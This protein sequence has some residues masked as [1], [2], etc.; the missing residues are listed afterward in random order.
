M[1]ESK[2]KPFVRLD[3]TSLTIPD[4]E[5][6]VRERYHVDMS[7]G[8]W[9]RIAEARA[10]VYE[11]IERGVTL[12]GVTTGVGSQKDYSFDDESVQEFNERLIRAHAP[13]IPGYNISPAEVRA[14]LLIL[15]NGY[16]EG[17]S[18]IRAETVQK[19]L[20]GLNGDFIPEVRDNCSVGAGDL[21]P[22][23][24][25]AAA[26][27][28]DSDIEFKFAAKEAL[29]L[30]CSNAISLAKAALAVIECHR[31]MTAIDLVGAVALEGFRGNPQALIATKMY[32]DR[33][34]VGQT[35]K[36]V[37]RIIE[38]LNNSALWQE[39][40][41]RFLQDPLS[42]RCIGHMHGAA[43]QTLHWTEQQVVAE[44]NT[45][46]DNPRVD[47]WTRSLLSHGNIDT[48]LLTLTLDTLRQALAKVARVSSERLHKQHWN[49]FSGLPVGL[50]YEGDARGGI[51]FLNL[52]HLAEA[53]VAQV[54]RFAAPV[55]LFYG[56]QLADGVE[57]TAGLAPIASQ[58]VRQMMPY[59]WNVISL[60]LITAVWAIHRRGVPVEN[61]GEG[62][63]PVYEAILPMLP[64]GKEGNEVFDIQPVVTWLK[65][66]AVTLVN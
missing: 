60:E 62:I 49:S 55:L 56:G 30:M 59:C 57:D 14:A 54:H 44:M 35:N 52:S 51:Q 40:Q 41:P 7:D 22:L 36:S 2:P 50:T 1:T 66:Y 28:S 37:N 5:R 17:T 39:G 63:R 11:A 38:W 4:I 19:L 18:G 26:F 53:Q 13:Y 46:T 9:E 15:L 43:W 42:F 23:A 58:Q 24:Q 48:T 25:M 33:D 47:V 45:S 64:I 3:G 34:K 10:V 12:Y 29:S 27:I 32:R 20:T 8:A 6:V 16:A 61:L 65:D 21:V 31:F